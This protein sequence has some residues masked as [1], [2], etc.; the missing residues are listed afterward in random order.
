MLP[1]TYVARY[2]F[3]KFTKITSFKTAMVDSKSDLEN[4]N[5]F[6]VQGGNL[7]IFFNFEV[8]CIMELLV[9]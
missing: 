2:Y 3:T 9:N 7:Y 4:W 8:N 1:F 5:N 6:S